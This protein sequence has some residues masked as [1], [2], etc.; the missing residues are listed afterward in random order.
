MLRTSHFPSK[1]ETSDICSIC[2]S[3]LIPG[4]SLLILSCNH[5][6]HFQCLTSSVQAQ[7]QLCPLCRASI[8]APIIQLLSTAHSGGDHQQR[9]L[10]PNMNQRVVHSNH[11][12]RG[13]SSSISASRKD[14]VDKT[15]LQ[16]ITAQAVSTGQ[17]ATITV[18]TML[19]FKG[20]LSQRQSNIYGLVSLQ[21][22]FYRQSSK[23]NKLSSRVPIDLVC[24][25][26]QSASMSGAKMFLLKKTLVYIT[27]Q[28]TDL[29]RL[30]I[31]SF[32]NHAYDR[33]HGFLQMNERNK[34]KLSIVINDE[35]EDGFSTNIG[36]GLEM[37]IELFRS[38]DTKNPVRA[39]FLL[40]DGKDDEPQDYSHI[41]RRLPQ[42]V[43]CHTFGYGADHAASL[44]VQLAEQG[45][46][47]TF[48]F[49]DTD[50]AVGSAF[51]IALAGLLTCVA[52]NIRVNIEFYGD[53]KVT[54]A[55]SAYTYEPEQLPS[56]KITF[57]LNNLNAD[58]KR[59][60]MFQLQV[61]EIEDKSS[62]QNQSILNHVI[63][64]VS[65][66]YDDPK[67]NLR[68]ATRPGPFH[69]I[70]ASNL[71]ADDLQVNYQIDLQRNRIETTLALRQAMD[72]QDYGRSL[73][74]LN[75]QVKNIKSSVSGEDPFCQQLIK[76]L[77]YR[78]PNEHAYRSTNYNICR[79][80]ATERGT[81]SSVTSSSAKVYNS[82][83][84]FHQMDH[85]QSQRE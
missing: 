24:V 74:L 11:Q 79:Q 5:K 4:T 39:L 46:N 21:T 78:Y 85:F 35:I 15:N 45:N 55:H 63:G 61:P 76:D 20:Q 33:S 57:K 58:E 56:S 59:N 50:D 72:E 26:D 64:H 32:D 9:H 27:E 10:S 71:S 23:T 12:H 6:F 7:H 22:P 77:E 81:Y 16:E 49:I 36:C 17:T 38:H 51:A 3:S 62:S 30:A 25:V 83:H 67:R 70:R 41:I 53:Y 73:E 68:F 65:V 14:F 42:D 29:D 69:L 84:Q 8:D 34:Y 75:A 66:V 54:H 19:E 40:T 44:L 52:Q 31:V 80:H 82:V 13:K 37:A 1:N 28:L 2:L 18:S 43:V 60:L 47:G 48:T